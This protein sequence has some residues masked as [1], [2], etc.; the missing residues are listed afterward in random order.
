MASTTAQRQARYRANRPIAGT[1][2][3]GERRLNTWVD[4]R[5]YFA[6]ARLADRYG[7]T[8][9]EMI[10][11]LVRTEDDRILETLDIEKPEWDQYM[12]SG[13]LRSNVRVDS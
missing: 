2:G 11:R 1:D 8:K 9:R 12:Q 13:T 6:L 3:N 7:V 5:T 4:S 10:E